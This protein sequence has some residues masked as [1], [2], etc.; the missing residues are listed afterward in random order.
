MRNVVA[1]SI[2]QRKL[3]ALQKASKAKLYE[4]RSGDEIQ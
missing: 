3:R 1:A 2:Y 4:E